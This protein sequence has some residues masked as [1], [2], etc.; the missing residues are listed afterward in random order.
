[1]KTIGDLPK[2]LEEFIGKH[3]VIK[4]N[5]V[6]NICHEAKGH[7]KDGFAGGE[8]VID[9]PLYFTHTKEPTVFSG[10]LRGTVVEEF[11]RRYE[12]ILIDPDDKELLKDA[13]TKI[14]PD[15]TE[16]RIPVNHSLIEIT[17]IEIQVSETEKKTIGI[18]YISL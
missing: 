6:H 5:K 16:I 17:E 14:N 9:V 8:W 1:M 15:P 7:W 12:Y 11:R 3:V 2:E 4:A 13:A 10:I 18:N